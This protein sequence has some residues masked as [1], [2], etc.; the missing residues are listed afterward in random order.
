MPTPPT[1]YQPGTRLTVGTHEVVIKKY[2][3]AGGFAHVYTV[4]VEPPVG[5]DLACLK[6]VVVPDKVFLN[7]LRAEVE[8][9]QRLQGAPNVVQYIDSHAERLKNG[10][11]GYE[12]LL[13]MEFCPGGGLIDFMNTRLKDQL[14]EFEIL[15]I[16]SDICVGVAQMHHLQ[17]P[18]IHRDLKIE[19]VLLTKDGR[20]YK[21]CD[22]GSV[23]PALR[24]PTNPVECQ[25][26]EDDINHHTTLQYRAP[27]MI[28]V[29]RGFPID[30][31]SDIWAL[32]IFL[33][34]LCYYT[35]PFERAGP[36][37]NAAILEGQVLF[38]P[39]PAYSERLK[40]M[41]RV[42]LQTNPMNRPNIDQVLEELSS[43]RGIPIQNLVAPQNPE[44]DVM[45]R[46]P[47]VEEIAGLPVRPPM[48]VKSP[49]Q[50][51]P[52][53][54]SAPSSRQSIPAASPGQA[55]TLAPA[56]VPGPL[57][58]PASSSVPG[59]SVAPAPKAPPR[60]L[61]K[62]GPKPG[63]KPVPESTITRA[64]KP[65]P[66][67][68]PT[69]AP[70][71]APLSSRSPPFVPGTVPGSASAASP[72]ALPNVGPPLPPKP[73]SLPSR[74]TKPSLGGVSPSKSHESLSILNGPQVKAPQTQPQQGLDELIDL[75]EEDYPMPRRPSVKKPPAGQ[76]Q[77]KLHRILT[78]LDEKSSTVV[79]ESKGPNMDSSVDFLRS[80]GGSE[81]HEK[82]KHN[83]KL[84]L[85]RGGHNHHRSWESHNSSLGD[86]ESSV[87]VES[88]FGDD[89]NDDDG[90][91]G[92]FRPS[93]SIQQ[94]VHDYLNRQSV[95]LEAPRTAKGY[96]KYTDNG[97][98][99]LQSSL[100]MSKSTP[101]LTTNLRKVET[102]SKTLGVPPPIP[103][104]H[105]KPRLLPRTQSDNSLASSA[106]S[107]EADE[108]PKKPRP[109]PTNLKIHKSSS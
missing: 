101:S 59:S 60:P 69:S 16:M 26:L 51:I 58:I 32:G 14:R 42:L 36:Q 54:T 27:E 45:K 90:E 108:P 64:P 9:M 43:M 35:T 95:E 75:D 37:I 49:V 81:G 94:R 71:S 100:G 47:S 30:E 24:V 48:T 66:T 52:A 31:K 39:R 84:S 62:P 25:I 89:L 11:H 17:P 67:S 3:S 10:E 6:R 78:G 44:E 57:M 29:T 40:N 96:G 4:Y 1:V 50:A 53:P 88:G 104:K 12:V 109:K 22:F 77:N 105:L 99:D 65:A 2:I 5:A 8:A 21:L 107:A 72:G 63:P 19:N 34:K 56:S 103:P 7:L 15:K 106:A 46:F 86:S 92:E 20:D 102:R 76:E 68:V 85:F 80:L 74:S 41:I 83:H 97:E 55:P 28:D 93:N 73:I 91:I 98:G 79:M 87:S 82:P 38:P 13:L 33:Y 61:P 23:S 18:I 70:T